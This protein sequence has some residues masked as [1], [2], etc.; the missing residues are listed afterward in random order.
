MSSFLHL[1]TAAAIFV[2]AT[3]GCCAHQSHQGNN[4]SNTAPSNDSCGTKHCDHQHSKELPSLEVGSIAQTLCH[5]SLNEGVNTPEIQ[6]Q[7]PESQ[8]CSHANCFWPFPEAR[9]NTDLILLLT[10]G[11]S[12]CDLTTSHAST[13]GNAIGT[14]NVLPDISTHNLSVRSHLVMRVL[15]I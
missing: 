11:I 3:L 6:A 4:T 10:D 13:L 14:S 8:E 5:A 15:L 1:L 7:R 2:H 9:T 12:Q